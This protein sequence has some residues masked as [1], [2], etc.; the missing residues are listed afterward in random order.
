[1][2]GVI[3]QPVVRPSLY[4]GCDKTVSVYVTDVRRRNVKCNPWRDVLM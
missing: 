2:Q 1:M 3:G 4:A